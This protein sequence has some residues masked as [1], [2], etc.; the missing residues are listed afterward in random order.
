MPAITKLVTLKYIFDESICNVYWIID[1]H[2]AG[3]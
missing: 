2:L 1:F 3:M